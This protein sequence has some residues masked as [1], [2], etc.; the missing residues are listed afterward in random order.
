[1]EASSRLKN[2]SSPSLDKIFSDLLRKYII[3]CKRLWQ[4]LN[5]CISQNKVPIR[6]FQSSDNNI[7][8]KKIL[9]HLSIISVQYRLFQTWQKYLKKVIK[10]RLIFYLESNYLLFKNQFGSRPNKSTDQAIANVTKLIY[11]TLE[12][13]KKCATIYLDLT[14][15]CGSW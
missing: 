4:I 1:M 8:I 3:L 14:K 13:G 9:L 10:T 12:E 11:T 7:Y 15:A 5:L 6:C 2:G